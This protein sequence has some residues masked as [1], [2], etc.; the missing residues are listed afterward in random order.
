VKLV[1]LVYRKP[2]QA[3]FCRED[4]GLRKPKDLE[5]NAIGTTAG[6]SV[7]PYFRPSP[8]PPA[9]MLGR[10]GGSWRAS[11]H[12]RGCS[13]PTRLPV[14]ANSQSAKRCCGLSSGL[15]NLYAGLFLEKNPEEFRVHRSL[16]METL[17]EL[18]R[19]G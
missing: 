9:S 12:C 6:A 5:G 16:R 17:F 1:A 13:R 4:S 11:S 2:P 15:A 8:K 7:R 18:C 3:I 10:S 14:S 19:R